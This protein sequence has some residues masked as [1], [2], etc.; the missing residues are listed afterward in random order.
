V[1]TFQIVG[2]GSGG[3]VDRWRTCSAPRDAL[4]LFTRRAGGGKGASREGTWVGTRWRIIAGLRQGTRRRPWQ[5]PATSS[6]GCQR[7]FWAL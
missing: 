1:V 7:G 6:E 4:A 3:A 2:P 5:Q